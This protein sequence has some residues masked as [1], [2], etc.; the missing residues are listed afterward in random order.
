MLTILRKCALLLIATLMFAGAVAAQQAKDQNGLEAPKSATSLKKPDAGR[1]A[2]SAKK[3]ADPSKTSG[4]RTSTHD[5]HKVQTADK[6]SPP[7]PPGDKQ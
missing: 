7:A 4:A 5:T 3:Q 2:T 1:P 6:Q